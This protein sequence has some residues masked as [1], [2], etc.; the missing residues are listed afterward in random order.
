M[1]RLTNERPGGRML[2]HSS[3]EQAIVRLDHVVSPPG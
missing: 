3:L 1:I 2:I